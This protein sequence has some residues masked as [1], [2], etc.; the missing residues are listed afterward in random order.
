LEKEKEQHY[1]VFEN[2]VL[3][4]SSNTLLQGTIVDIKNQTLMV[5]KCNSWW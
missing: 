5:Q 3:G 4:Q 1:T 2:L